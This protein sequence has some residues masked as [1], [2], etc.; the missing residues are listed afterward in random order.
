MLKDIPSLVSFSH[1]MLGFTGHSFLPAKAEVM[2]YEGFEMLPC[3]R[4]T[5]HVR[6]HLIQFAGTLMCYTVNICLALDADALVKMQQRQN[7][8]LST[9]QNPC[10]KYDYYSVWQE[11]IQKKNQKKNGVTISLEASGTA[12]KG[13]TSKEITSK[14]PS[15]IL[16]FFL[17]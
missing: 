15:I 6:I 10:G 13:K 8:L 5:C 7:S 2:E 1:L 4:G 12:S 11:R 3:E 17:I 16:N 9:V 14:H